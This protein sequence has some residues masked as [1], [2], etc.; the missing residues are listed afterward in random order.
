MKTFLDFH[1]QCIKDGRRTPKAG[2]CPSFLGADQKLFKLFEPIEDDLL[3]YKINMFGSTPWYWGSGDE[4]KR[5][6]EYTDFR[7]TIVLFC[8]VIN[9]EL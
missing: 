3:N 1:N 6:G 2:V 9:G 5:A 4:F 7:E 8:A